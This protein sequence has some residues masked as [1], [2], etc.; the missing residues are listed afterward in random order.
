MSHC[1]IR[2]V[3]PLRESDKLGTQRSLVCPQWLRSRSLTYCLLQA[4]YWGPLPPDYVLFWDMCWFPVAAVRNYHKCSGF[5]NMS[6]RSYS[7]GGQKSEIGLT[8]VKAS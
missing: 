7:S 4:L 5:S 2:S 8:G 6:S 1:L 3:K